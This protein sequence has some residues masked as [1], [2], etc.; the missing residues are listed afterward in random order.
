MP[1]LPPTSGSAQ[2]R[3]QNA[4]EDDLIA[5]GPLREK[6][7]KRK[8][9]R[10]DNED[11]YIDSKSSRK[12]LKIGQELE[13]EDRDLT[14]AAPVNSAF[15]FASRLAES[16]DLDEGAQY[17][18]EEAWGDEDGPEG[19]VSAPKCQHTWSGIDIS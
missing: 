4:L 18:D 17:D 11:G 19:D 7:K 9:K 10:D 2:F 16:S 12:I 5:T 1:T 15:T 3:H 13:E 14:E 8:A 6:S